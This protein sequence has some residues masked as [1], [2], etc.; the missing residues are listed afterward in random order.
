MNC[1]TCPNCLREKVPIKLK[2]CNC[3][4]IF[5]KKSHR[6]P[7]RYHSIPVAN[8]KHVTSEVVTD[9]EPVPHIIQSQPVITKS[10]PSNMQATKN[11]VTDS[12]PVPPIVQSQPVITKS[13]PSNLQA[14]KDTVTDSDPVPPIVQ[15]QPVITK[16]VPSNL[17]ATKDTVTD[18]D[19]VPPIIHTVITKSVPSNVWVAE[20]TVTNSGSVPVII[21]SQPAL[22]KSDSSQKWEKL[23]HTV[24]ARRKE[25]YRLNSLLAKARAYK[26]YHKNPELSKIRKWLAYKFNPSPVKERVKKSYKLNPSPVKAHKREAY[27]LNPSPVKAHKREVYRLNPSPIKE[28]AKQCY[29]LNP[30]PVKAH[31]REAYRLNP[32]PVKARKREMYKANPSPI[33]ERSRLAYHINPTSAKVRSKAAYHKD[34][35]GIKYKSRQSYK[36]LRQNLLDRR[37]LQ[38]LLACAVSKKYKKLRQHLPDNF[39]KY[40]SNVIR[41]ITRRKISSSDIE[42]EHLV[43]TCMHFKEMNCKRFVSAFKKLKLS[44]L[45]T[46]SKLLDT[47]DDPYEILFGPSMHTTS[48]ESFFPTSTYHEAALD[49]DGNVDVTKFPT[50]DNGKK[51]KDWACAPGLCKLDDKPEITKTV[52]KIY[53]SIG[54]C[55]PIEARHYIQHMDDCDQPEPHDPSLAGHNKLCHLDTDACKYKLLYLRRLAP[56]F[57]NVRQLVNMIYTVKSTDKQMCRID[58]ALQTGNV[59]IL[60]QISTEQKSAYQGSNDKSINSIDE[61]K[62][63]EAFMNAFVAFKSRCLECAE[64]P[65]MSCNKL[66]FKHE[67]V[68]LE[69]CRLPITGNAWNL[70]LEYLDRH[71][72]PDD[73]LSTGYICKFCIE[74]FR[75][76]TIPSRC[77]LNGLSFE[78]VPTEILQLNQHER[79]LIQRAKAFQVVTK[80]HTVAG[81]RLPPSHKVSKVK[82]STFHLPLPLNETLKRLPSPEEP[83]PPNGELYALLRSIPTE[84]NNLARFS[85]C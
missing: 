23:K 41:N 64:F 46:L 58:Q 33:K 37:S 12:D 77:V 56:H 19:P 66:C 49:E 71:P 22:S 40:A 36:F 83:L 10:V 42:V 7:P 11:T 5:Y 54:E 69:W 53:N 55:D 76:D 29:N 67:C 74:K 59:E 52:C 84:K 75:N 15:S 63:L 34:G 9:S 32:S 48:S 16:S 80:M 38:K 14:T 61:T 28:R 68:L 50:I 17:Q 82:G 2:V 62:V 78:N 44:V 4:H 24:N 57:P 31:K 13:V 27:R 8:Y 45:A 20:D 35:E 1:K 51:Q 39:S 72:V 70:L 60:Q 26:L 6:Q 79:V 65:C 3:G 25:K 81:K 73:S 47:T 30:S 18:S 21:Q 85:K 43:K